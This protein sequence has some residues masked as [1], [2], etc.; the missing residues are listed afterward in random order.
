MIGQLAE[1]RLLVSSSM[2]TRLTS[3]PILLVD[4]D[5]ASETLIRLSI[6]RQ[7]IPVQLR[8]VVSPK[9]ALDYLS[10]EGPYHDRESYPLPKLLL[11]DSNLPGTSGVELIHTIRN[12]LCL[13]RV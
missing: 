10:G 9:Q 8:S 7:I 4:D 13:S 3:F 5:A 12:E 6:D 1:V 11:L 2:P